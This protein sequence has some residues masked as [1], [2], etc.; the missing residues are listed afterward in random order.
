[1]CPKYPECD[2][3]PLSDAQNFADAQAPSFVE[4]VEA[5]QNAHY[6]AEAETIATGP[7]ETLLGDQV[8]SSDRVRCTCGRL[9]R[10]WEDCL[11]TQQAREAY[12]FERVH[13]Q[14]GFALDLNIFTPPMADRRAA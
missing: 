10:I 4:M 11:C 14:G 12:L 6:D 8:E 2:V 1:L 7:D 3:T 9:R 5:E 13:G